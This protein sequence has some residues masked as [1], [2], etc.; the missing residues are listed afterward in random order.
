MKSVCLNDA[1][2]TDKVVRHGK[3]QEVSEKFN[4]AHKSRC[5]AS[6]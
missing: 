6:N 4:A 3:E 5:V 1:V 2:K